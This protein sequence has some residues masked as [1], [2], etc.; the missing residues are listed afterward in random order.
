MS[1][2]SWSLRE[3]VL[4]SV[5]VEIAGHR[6]SAASVGLRGGRHVVGAHVTM[7][8]PDGAVVPS[9]TG[10]NVVNKAAVLAAV[11]S[12][13]SAVGSPRRVGLIIPDPVAKV[14]LVKFQ[15]VPAR[16]QDLDQLIQWQV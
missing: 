7:R 13:L 10:T 12:V 9:L 2:L 4:P 5:A 14:S 8:L 16:V 6:V 15:Q 11:K 1:R 3:A